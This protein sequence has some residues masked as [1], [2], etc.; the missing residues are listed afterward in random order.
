MPEGRHTNAGMQE[1]RPTKRV[2]LEKPPIAAPEAGESSAAGK[3]P[4]FPHDGEKLSWQ[5]SYENLQ[6]YKEAFGDCNVP[7]KFKMN[8][9]LGGW[10]VSSECIASGS[11]FNDYL[12]NCWNIVPL[13][14]CVSSLF[15]G[16]ILSLLY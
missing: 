12:Q 4:A 10:V 9:K 16:L 13:I 8:M 7:Q 6:V 3:S 14:S 2:A 11:A 15:P 1:M 5:Q